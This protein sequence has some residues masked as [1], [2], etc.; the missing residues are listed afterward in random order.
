MHHDDSQ[1]HISYHNFHLFFPI[2]DRKEFG[3]FQLLKNFKKFGLMHRPVAKDRPWFVK[4]KFQVL[5]L[6]KLEVNP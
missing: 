5:G 6:L 1:K 4:F 2:C 3:I